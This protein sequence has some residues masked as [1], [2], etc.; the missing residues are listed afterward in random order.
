MQKA[1]RTHCAAKVATHR[2]PIYSAFQ[3]SQLLGLGPCSEG[4]ERSPRMLSTSASRI[5]KVKRVLHSNSLFS[6]K[7]TWLKTSRLIGFTSAVSRIAVSRC[8][9]LRWDWQPQLVGAWRG[10]RAAGGGDGRPGA[11]FR[12]TP[13]KVRVHRCTMHHP[14]HHPCTQCLKSEEHPTWSK[15]ET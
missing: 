5:F 9:S 13:R 1:K 14:R 15:Q 2:P 3:P 7:R 6:F 11:K 4:S 8:C 10:W 12:C